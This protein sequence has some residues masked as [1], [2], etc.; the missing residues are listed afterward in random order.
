[1]FN[2]AVIKQY[3]FTSFICTRGVCRGHSVILEV[4]IYVFILFKCNPGSMRSRSCDIWDT[5]AP[6]TSMKEIYYRYTQMVRTTSSCSLKFAHSVIWESWI[7]LFAFKSI[8]KSNEA[9]DKSVLMLI[10]WS[11]RCCTSDW[12]NDLLFL[13]GSVR[14][15]FGLLD[16]RWIAKTAE[17]S[18]CKYYAWVQQSNRLVCPI[19]HV[20]VKI[21]CVCVQ[22]LLFTHSMSLLTHFLCVCSLLS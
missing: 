11:W 7:L 22:H 14:T 6:S 13:A 19:C 4:I 10:T 15:S 2:G 21:I 9:S 18:L 16:S 12:L 20:R 5:V 8:L 3:I 1:M 17:L